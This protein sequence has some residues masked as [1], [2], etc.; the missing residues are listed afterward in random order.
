MSSSL[1]ITHNEREDDWGVWFSVEEDSDPLTDALGFCL[2]GGATRDEAVA[3][4]VA[5][6]EDALK[7]LQSPRGVVSEVEILPA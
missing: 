1:V 6:L 5:D 7:R 2:A 4:A 3:S